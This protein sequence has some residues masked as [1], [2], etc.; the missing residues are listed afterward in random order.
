MQLF[1][2]VFDPFSDFMICSKSACERQRFCS[3]FDFL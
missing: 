3:I 1:D 2:K